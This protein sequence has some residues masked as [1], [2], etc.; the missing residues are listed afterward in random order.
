MSIDYME[1]SQNVWKFSDKWT[2]IRLIGDLWSV[3]EFWIPIRTTSGKRTVIPKLCLDWDSG[4]HKSRSGTCPY[5][6]AGLEGRPIYYS[7]A[8]IRSLQQP[9]PAIKPLAPVC[10]I[11]IPPRFY[12]CL[13]NFKAQNFKLTKSG[14]RKRFDVS[15]PIF[16]CDINVK[17][18]PENSYGYYDVERDVPTKLSARELA[19]PVVNLAIRPEPASVARQEWQKL[20]ALYVGKLP[21]NPEPAHELHW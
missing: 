14:E 16:G 12:Q 4:N 13:R 1:F 8:I 5:C 11:K 17:I 10:V 7:N 18:N 21:L 20:R 15:H 6:Q 9:T 2:T 3:Y 19:Y